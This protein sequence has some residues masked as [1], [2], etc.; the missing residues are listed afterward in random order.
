MADQYDP[1]TY[2]KAPEPGYGVVASTGDGGSGNLSGSGTPVGGQVPDFIGQLYAD[3]DTPGKV[4]Q[5][6]GLTSADWTQI[7][8]NP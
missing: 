1:G 3:I 7:L 2:I 4:W 8:G 6:T 5:S